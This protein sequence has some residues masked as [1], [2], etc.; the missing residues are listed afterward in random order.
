MNP[1]TKAI[2][3]VLRGD[4]NKFKNIME[5]ALRDRA[6]SL[7]EEKY[8][9]EGMEILFNDTI[10]I[11]SAPV[12]QITEEL[13]LE[14]SFTTKDGSVIELTEEQINSVGKLY[15]NLN[16]NN[17][18]RLLKLLSESEESVNKILNLAKIQRNKNGK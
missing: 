5:E 15:K 16:N 6:A 12:Q 10:E 7:L 3:M 1:Y 13:V 2:N 17:K 9:Q 8:Y 11:P 18:E 14:P 4:T